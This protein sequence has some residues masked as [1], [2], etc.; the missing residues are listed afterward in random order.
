MQQKGPLSYPVFI[1]ILLVCLFGAL[2]ISLCFGS[3]S[4]PVADVVRTLIN[5]VS[6]TAP[7]V[8]ADRTLVT[9]IWDLRLARAL[10]AAL[11]GASLAGSGVVFQGL[12]RNPLAEPFIIGASSGAALGATIAIITGGGATLLGLGAVP[13]AAFVGA[14]GAVGLVFVIA[15]SGSSEP[16]AVSLLLAGT[17][18]SALFSSIVSFLM[19]MQDKDLHKIFFWILGG[20]SGLSWN[21]F[22][23]VLPYSLVSLIVLF[24]LSRPLDIMAFG[25]ESAKGMGLSVGHARLLIVIFASIATAAA[26]ATCG[27][28]GFVG[29]IAPHIARLLVGHLHRRLLPAACLI[30]AVLLVLADVAARVVLAPMEIPVGVLTAMLGAPFFLYLLKTRQH[31]LGNG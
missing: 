7:E 4:I 12:F 27:I 28:I 24:F 16:P 1:L 14:I 6:G 10:L 23:S 2:I 26:V 29:L 30:G 20:F 25:E 11:V 19:S 17:A 15:R 9:I 21:S 31:S 8:R 13:G 22:F 5:R 18:L 3:V